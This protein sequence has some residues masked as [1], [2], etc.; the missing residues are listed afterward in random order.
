VWGNFFADG[1]YQ[2]YSY[3]GGWIN[4]D[5]YAFNTGFSDPTGGIFI[6]RP[7][8]SDIIPPPVIPEPTSLLL[9]GTGLGILYLGKNRLR[10][11]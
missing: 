9:L 4:H 7:D 6:A 2:T 8:G 1:S 10:K 11:K 3:C 5:L